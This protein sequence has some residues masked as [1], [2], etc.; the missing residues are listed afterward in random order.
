MYEQVDGPHSDTLTT[1]PARAAYLVHA[2]SST[3]FRRAVQEAFHPA[4]LA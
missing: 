2:G 1:V 4:G 3:G